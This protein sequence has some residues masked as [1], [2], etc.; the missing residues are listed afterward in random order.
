MELHQEI[1]IALLGVEGAIQSRTKKL[2]PLDMKFAAELRQLR[3]TR[4]ND[5]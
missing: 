4:G 2:Q 3:M 5:A 1:E